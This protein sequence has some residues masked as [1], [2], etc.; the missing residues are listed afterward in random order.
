MAVMGSGDIIAGSNPSIPEPKAKAMDVKSLAKGAA[1]SRQRAEANSG[2]RRCGAMAQQRSDS[3]ATST[4][5]EFLHLIGCRD[6]KVRP[7]GGR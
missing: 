7:P 6:P 3:G 1:A 5:Q 2:E 4:P